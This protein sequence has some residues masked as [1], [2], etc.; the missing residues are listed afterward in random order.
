VAGGSRRV[1]GRGLSR[2]DGVAVAVHP[3]AGVV[4]GQVAQLVEAVQ[5]AGVG[6]AAVYAGLDVVQVLHDR[7]CVRY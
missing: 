7:T 4:L 2:H 6:G 3:P 5:V 1:S